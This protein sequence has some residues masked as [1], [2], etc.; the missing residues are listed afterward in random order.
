MKS[1]V[2]CANSKDVEIIMIFD[3]EK[4]YIQLS[5]HKEN[6]IS[7]VFVLMYNTKIIN[8]ELIC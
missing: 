6:N 5:K 4:K 8:D 7:F 2:L 1:T 3:K